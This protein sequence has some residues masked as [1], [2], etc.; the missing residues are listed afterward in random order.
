MYNEIKKTIGSRK[1]SC[2]GRRRK[3][4][5][6][7]PNGRASMSFSVTYRSS[8][9]SLRSFFARL[10]RMTGAYVSGTVK[11]MTTQQMP[12][13][14]SWIQYSHLHPAASPRKP[15]AS[16]PMAGPMKGAALNTAIGTP[17]SSFF[18]KSASVPPTRVMGAEKAIPSM[19]R[20]TRRVPMFCATA[21]G[22]TKMTAIAR[23]TAYTGLRP[24]ISLLK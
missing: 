7:W 18:H 12:E 10:S 13:R 22:I 19:R 16:G 9:V 11:V 8:P 5:S 3:M 6:C 14:I 21:Q 1:R 4:R 20:H 2:R 23:V 24:N 15:P 17:L